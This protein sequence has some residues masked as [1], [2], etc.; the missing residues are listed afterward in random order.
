MLEAIV[1]GL[2]AAYLVVAAFGVWAWHREVTLDRRKTEL[3]RLFDL[4]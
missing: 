4:R 3:E 1:V 2:A